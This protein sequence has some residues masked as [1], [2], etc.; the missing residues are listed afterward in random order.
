[1]KALLALSMLLLLSGC[2][3]K[4]VRIYD[5]TILTTPIHCLTLTIEPHNIMI[6]QTMQRLY[7]FKKECDF[8][9]RITH[10]NA[11]TCNANFNAQTKAIEGM[12]SS[13]LSM[14]IKEG[15]ARKYS[16]Y[17]DL[18]SDVD[19]EDLES[20]FSHLQKSLQIH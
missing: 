9:L 15:D 16:Y 2:D 11:I 19:E 5:K 6:D 7:P 17:V 13:Y 8:T 18:E 10:R 12:P 20:G 3:K 1:M 4:I 14:E